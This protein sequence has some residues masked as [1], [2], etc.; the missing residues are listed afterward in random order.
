MGEG[1]RLNIRKSSCQWDVF[2]CEIFSQGKE[3]KASLFG[4][5]AGQNCVRS[6]SGSG[7]G[8]E[9]GG[10]C[11]WRSSR[12]TRGSGWMHGEEKQGAGRLQSGARHKGDNK[13]SNGGRAGS[14]RQKLEN[15]EKARRKRGRS[16]RHAGWEWS[17]ENTRSSPESKRAGMSN[18]SKVSRLCREL[19]GL[20]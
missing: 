6:S 16:S 15:A 20:G 10:S 19:G 9:K 17:V 11:A 1:N 8:G 4:S 3:V 14:S 18:N 2:G 5:G 13:G 12:Y 7:G